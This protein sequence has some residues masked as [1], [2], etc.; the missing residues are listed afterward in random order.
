MFAGLL[1]LAPSTGRITP[2]RARSLIAADR[3]FFATLDDDIRGFAL[4]ALARAL[5]GR[6]TA[7]I[8]LRPQACL[9]PGA[10]ARLKRMLFGALK[11]TPRITLIAIVPQAFA[12]AQ[13]AVTDCWMHDPQ[14]WDR[15]DLP[16]K[17]D[18]ATV[19]RIAGFAAGRRVLVFLGRGS[20]IKGL[21]QLA[22]LVAARPALAQ[23]L[24]IVVAGQIDGDCASD[25]ERLAAFGAE[26]WNRRVSEEE[27]AALY[28]AAN[29][30]WACYDPSYDQ[31]SGIFGRSV[32]L[33]R[34]AVIREGAM[35]ARYAALLGHPVVALPQS[36][37]EAADRLARALSVDEGGADVST[38][39]AQW[40][41]AALGVMKNAL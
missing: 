35:I 16:V 32:Q 7:G 26:I 28:T 36:P 31:A 15:I 30:V 34:P 10:K 1:G 41:A 33:G 18:A 39:V 8:F 20:R 13:Q 14:L 2:G 23:E 22:A 40:R 5:L 6:R 21:P 9:E 12:P 38:V 19:A 11:A 4:V 17:P 29:L 3:L 37:P 24:A 25:A 27:M